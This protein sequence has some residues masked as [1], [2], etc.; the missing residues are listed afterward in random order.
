PNMLGV[1]G[2][3]TGFVGAVRVAL[4]RGEA[5]QPADLFWVLAA[6]LIPVSLAIGNI[7]RTVDWPA[8]AGPIELAI[9]SHLAAAL[10]LLGAILLLQGGEAFSPLVQVP[11][12]VLA[13]AASASAMFAF[14]L[15]LRALRGPVSPSPVGVVR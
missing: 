1:A 4:T 14:F 2:I 9:G 6:L 13:Q 10:I 12:V 3:V 11:G 8:G 5:G 15:R 7:Y